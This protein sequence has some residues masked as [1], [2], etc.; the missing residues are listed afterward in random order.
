MISREKIKQIFKEINPDSD[1]SFQEDAVSFALYIARTA[2]TQAIDDA[3]QSLETVSPDSDARTC[4]FR[5][6]SLKDQ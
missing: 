3:V 6:K 2:Y 4:L 5:I 1:Y